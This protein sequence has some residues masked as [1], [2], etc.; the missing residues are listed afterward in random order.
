MESKSSEILTDKNIDC[1]LNIIEIAIPLV[2]HS[3]GN[4][5]LFSSSR[6]MRYRKEEGTV[7]L[8]EFLEIQEK[9]TKKYLENRITFN[10]F[11]LNECYLKQ[12]TIIS[13]LTGGFHCM[14]PMISEEEDM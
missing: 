3:F 2:L 4:I 5:T 11:A 7:T 8:S 10:L 9:I 13:R 12:F 6:T 1:T 14:A